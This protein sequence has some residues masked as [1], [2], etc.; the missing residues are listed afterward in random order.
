MNGEPRGTARGLV[1]LVARREI[2]ARARTKAFAILTALMVTAVVAL[3]VIMKLVGGSGQATS[4]V[5]LL[6]KEASLSAPLA[7]AGK[8]V[9][10]GIRTRSV[11]DRAAGERLIRDGK[12]DALVVSSANGFQ[13]EVEKSADYDKLNGAVALAAKGQALRAEAVRLGAN[14]AAVERAVAAG[15]AVH[16]SAL[17]HEHP[18][19]AQRLIIGLVAGF[20]IY[21]TV[22][23]YGQLIAQGVVEE[24]SSRVVELLLAALKPWQLMTGKVLGTGLVG[25]AQMTVTAIAGLA[26]G[27]SL[28]TLSL[29]GSTAVAAV[30]WALLW[31]VL[32]FFLYAFVFAAAGA[33]VSRQE[34]VAGASLPILMPLIAAWVLGVSI[35]PS[36][37][38]SSLLAVL[39]VI[40][41]LSPV[42]MPMRIAMGV[43]AG[44][45]IGLSVALT[46][47]LLV[48]MARVSGMVYRNSVLRT[49]ARVRLSEALRPA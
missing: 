46:V 29:P 47:V 43:A 3:A 34:D 9:G 36:E 35:L 44:W 7:A 1:G 21:L 19:D 38:D 22:M 11:P 41:I 40:P 48:A 24:K 17:H 18:Y 4:T 13:V 26:A 16:V 25:L 49:G 45:E 20:L 10:H 37:P 2:N 33:L 23:T 39:S 5:G 15:S 6:P 31:Y 28:G 8:A 12:L 30:A 42:L 32:G 27:L 14:P